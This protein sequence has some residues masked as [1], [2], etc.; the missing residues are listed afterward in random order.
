MGSHAKALH[1]GLRVLAIYFH[2]NVQ[3]IGAGTLC[4]YLVHSNPH[5]IVITFSH[6]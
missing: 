3:L 2:M 6:R 5:I 4:L 1:I